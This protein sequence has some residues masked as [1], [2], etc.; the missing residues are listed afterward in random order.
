MSTMTTARNDGWDAPRL[1]RATIFLAWAIFFGFLWFSGE[2]TRYL[3]PRT[4]WVVAFGT[5]VLTIASV[6]HFPFLR[7]ER[8]SQ[9][10]IGQA[11]GY[12]LTVL[13]IAVVLMAPDADL[14]AQAASRKLVGSELGQAQVTAQ[15]DRSGPLSFVDIFLGSRSPEYASAAGVE[16]GESIKL[17]G[18]VTDGDSPDAFRLTRFYISCCAADAIPYWAEIR[19]GSDVA[20]GDDTWLQVEGVIGRGPDGYFVDATDIEEVEEPDPPYLY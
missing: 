2:V 11:L 19:S 7:K 17:I 16:E 6:A 4:Q 1:A 20:Y 18:F 14:G 3:G 5:I 10:S 12:L 8:E 13:P 15:V 9:L